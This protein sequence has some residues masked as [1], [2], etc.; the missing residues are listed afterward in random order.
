MIA[1]T[2]PELADV[3]LAEAV[4]CIKY[5]HTSHMNGTGEGGSA[6]VKRIIGSGSFRV[7]VDP[8]HSLLHCKN[9][10]TC[11]SHQPLCCCYSLH[12]I[13]CQRP[14]EPLCSTALATA[15]ATAGCH[16]DAGA[17]V[18]GSGRLLHT[19]AC[20]WGASLVLLVG[21]S[22]ST[23]NIGTWGGGREPFATLI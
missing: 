3:E 11:G 7:E 22:L 6:L 14:P 19:S 18:D 8:Q 23:I 2:V 9:V 4:S 10:F 20:W 12:S 13:C 15:L 21:Q 5:C 1:R 17:V 16:T